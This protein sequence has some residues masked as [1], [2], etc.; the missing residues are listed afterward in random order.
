MTGGVFAFA[1]ALALGAIALNR[2]GSTVVPAP[3]DL[4]KPEA[5]AESMRLAHE[6]SAQLEK[7]FQS[8][9]DLLEE[10]DALQDTVLASVKVSRKE[11]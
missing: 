1:A 3:E 10:D 11:L 2:F 5:E 8:E 9:K 4:G 6:K 7:Q